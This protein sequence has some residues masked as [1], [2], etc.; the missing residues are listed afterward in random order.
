[1]TYEPTDEDWAAT[2]DAPDDDD[3]GDF[4]LLVQTIHAKVQTA[5]KRHLC[6][7]CGEFIEPGEKY[8]SM[9]YRFEDQIKRVKYHLNER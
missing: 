6:T 8:S 3:G 2:F 9:V 5:R 4:D 1:M 7:G